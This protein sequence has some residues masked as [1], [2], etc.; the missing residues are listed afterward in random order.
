MQWVPLEWLDPGVLAGEALLDNWMH[1][2][3]QPT[4]HLIRRQDLQAVRETED[5]HSTV[6]EV[7]RRNQNR[8]QEMGFSR[9]SSL[10][11]PDGCSQGE[12]LKQDTSVAQ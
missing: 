2:S 11:A 5:G 7:Q 9:L 1:R 6:S 3:P 10:A 4:I 12:V 8:L